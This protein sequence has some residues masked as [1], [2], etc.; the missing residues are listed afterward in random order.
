MTEEIKHKKRKFLFNPL[1]RPLPYVGL[2]IAIVLIIF[3]QTIRNYVSD[4]IGDILVDSMKEATDGVYKTTYD[5]VRFDIISK[6]LR[7]SN[8]KIELD[9]TVI[10][11]E[12]Y[13][14]KRPNLIDVHTP[15]IIVKLRSIL[16]LLLNKQLYIS[17]IGAKEPKF[18]LIKSLH[19][20]VEK[21]ATK[22]SKEDFREVINTYFSAL[23]VDSFRVEKGTFNISTH[24]ENE[25]ELS[26]IH[27]GEFTTMLQNFRLDS[28]SPSILLKGMRARSFEL[29]IINQN[30]NLPNIN[31]HIHFSKL[32]LSTVDSTFVLDSL[33][34]KNIEQNV[35]KSNVEYSIKK[36]EIL[37]FNFEKAFL[38]NS[39]SVNEIHVVEPNVF[40]EQLDFTKHKSEK[41]S[42]SGGI[43][44]Y[45]EQLEINRIK[46]YNGA[47]EFKGE[48]FSKVDNFS[49]DIE[50]YKISPKDWKKKKAVSDFKLMHIYAEG[51]T[52]EL[53]D[54]IHLANIESIAYNENENRL[55]LNKLSIKPISG[56]NS[57]KT[58]KS[59]HTNFSTYSNINS[60]DLIRFIPE[61][62]V[63]KNELKIDSVIIDKP[64]SSVVQYPGMV[65]SHIKRKD[66]NLKFTINHFIANNGSLKLRAYQNKR[67]R[68]SKLN[69]IYINS[70]AITEATSASN[71]PSYFR[72]LVSSGS[73]QISSIGH[74][75]TFK[76]LKIDQTE[77]VFI[78]NATIKPD[79]STLPY[80]HI[81]AG[82]SNVL[83]KG[84][85]LGE[86]QS[87]SLKIDSVFIDH[88]HLNS[89]FTRLPFAQEKK[90]KKNTLKS[91]AIRKFNIKSADLDSKQKGSIINL[92][93]ASIGFENIIIDSLQVNSKPVIAFNN[94]ILNIAKANFNET[95]NKIRIAGKNIG[96]VEVDS[97]FTINNIEYISEKK[98]D[99]IKLKALNIYGL[100]K[101][102]LEFKNE[103]DI[104]KLELIEPSINLSTPKTDSLK[105]PF[106]LH[107]IILAKG[108]AAIN[109]DTLQLINGST[110][111]A[112]PNNKK[113][114]LSSFKGIITNYKLDTTTTIFSAI[115][116]FKG[117]FEFEDIY[118]R[119]LT[120]TFSVAKV[121]L[122]TYQS[123]IWTDSIHFNAKLKKNNIKILSPGLAID[124][125]DIPKLLESKISISQIS[126][127]NNFVTL[128]QTDTTNKNT[129][130]FKIP[131]IYPTM[132]IEIGGINIV[133]TNFKYDKMG[134]KKH[135]L[136]H[137]NFDI[138][139]D[140]LK[141]IKGARF[142]LA[143]N[144]VDSR[145]R[146]YDF[147]FDLPD[148]LNTIG[149]DTLLVSS[150]KSQID[151]TNFTL[152]ARYPKYEYGNQVGHQVD[153]KDLLFKRVKV[154]NID[155][156]KLI[157]DKT[158]KCQ[159][160]TLENGHLK[161]FKDKQLPF[162]KDRVVPILQ[163]RVKGLKMPLKIDSIEIKN[164]DIYQSTLQSTGLQEGGITFMDTEA[165]ITNV[166]NDSIRLENNKMLSVVASSQIMGSGNLF[167]EMNFD[168]LDVNNLFFFDARLGSMDAKAFN[169]ILEAAAFVKVKNGEIRS[170]NLHATGNK[171]YAYGD[172]SFIYNDLKIETINKKTLETKGMG[173]VL[174]T[175]FANAFVVKK[176]NSRIKFITR[177]GGMYY[178]RNTGRITLDYMAKTALSGVVSSIGA[179]SNRKQIK[180]ITKDNKAARDLELK[181]Q[182]E[183]DK[184]AK[185]KAKK[186]Q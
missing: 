46:L 76:G 146:V 116:N 165:L 35:G 102:K 68:L 34:I 82:V 21:E 50:N 134:K 36:L 128:T 139:L 117:V 185:K 47:L 19:S 5:L 127:R 26:V 97:T 108:L 135:L 17:F 106:D 173:K 56:R 178:E 79:S 89:N 60:I 105:T 92:T 171:K 166:T 179:K 159:K 45:F 164:F 155:F 85:G 58:L 87:Q 88:L 132:Q 151:L 130:P 3:Q 63:L 123:F 141:A 152:T 175:F 170:L 2:I 183:L 167:A 120:D 48:R 14:L 32:Q 57:Y 169:N 101:W 94:T 113:L 31:Q 180:Q 162:P 52:Q 186:E 140:S 154:E 177:R 44:D 143:T 83:V 23:E 157:E 100:D 75:A 122:N 172:M 7:I 12:D 9:T 37:G 13:L 181:Q 137:L 111:V 136:A 73:T 65:L 168:M 53:P 4:T 51:M 27:I 114:D 70:S 69:G 126:T 133:N 39:I 145:F 112:L 107:K 176:N 74:T 93:D 78:E 115:N 54:S 174:K 138:K 55:R 1:K 28:L 109:L 148:S 149:F 110:F 62:L 41:K 90:T 80:H 84:I 81:N 10:S 77:S 24:S 95:K 29:E 25:K 124:Y 153:W 150:R 20:S 96:Y 161:L 71:L 49:I 131:E 104:R 15:I 147:S 42:N 66:S 72:L 59:R 22:N 40:F 163:E 38:E 99:L 86:L 91:I 103:L 8:L 67:N 182:K 184:A 16:P 61:D 144:T 158:L 30:V 121:H 18:S 125:I 142:H 129:K 98:N 6:E 43:F 160:I 64:T 118:L 33:V 119:G 11:K 156:V